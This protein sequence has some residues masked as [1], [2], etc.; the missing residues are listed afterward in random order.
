MVVRAGE[1][2]WS[3]MCD[4]LPPA[5]GKE[6]KRAYWACISVRKLGFSAK[7][8]CFP[9]LPKP[10]LEMISR[11]VACCKTRSTWMI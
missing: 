3:T 1:Y 11:A 6:M 8:K 10:D 2:D 9:S 7:L 4:A 5:K